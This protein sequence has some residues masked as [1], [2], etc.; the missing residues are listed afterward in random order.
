VAQVAVVLF[1]APL[2]NVRALREDQNAVRY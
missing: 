1:L 2:V